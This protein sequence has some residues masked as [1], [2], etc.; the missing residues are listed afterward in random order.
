MHRIVNRIGGDS[1]VEQEQVE[2]LWEAIS[3]RN[4]ATHQQYLDAKEEA[5]NAN[6]KNGVLSRRNAQQKQH[7]ATLERDVQSYKQQAKA[8][9]QAIK[10][11]QIN[12][13]DTISLQEIHD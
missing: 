13:I 2:S 10:S 8:A 6:E 4:N 9:L 3:D 5:K 1:D 12:K 7:I 11:L